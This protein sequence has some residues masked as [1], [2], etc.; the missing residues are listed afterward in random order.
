M[1]GKYKPGALTDVIVQHS[2]KNTDGGKKTKV[3]AKLASL[4]SP[5]NAAQNNQRTK[6]KATLENDSSDDVEG[7]QA[8]PGI[9]HETFQKKKKKTDKTKGKSVSKEETKIKEET[10]N[11]K[12]PRDTQRKNRKIR[13]RDETNDSKTVF[14]GN[15]PVSLQKKDL[16]KLFKTCGKIVSVRFR[17]PPTKDPRIPKKVISIKKDFHPERPTIVGFVCFEE[18]KSAQKALKLNGREVE[19]RHIRVDLAS[20]SKEHNHRCSVFVGNLDV[21]IDE[22]QIW[23][24]FSDCG[25]IVSVRII[26]DNKTGLGKGFCYIQFDSP[27]AVGLASHLNGSKLASREIRVMRSQENPG[28]PK[29]TGIDQKGKP[30]A[31]KN[32]KNKHGE[33]TV[34][35][36]KS[37]KKLKKD[38][39][40]KKMRSSDAKKVRKNKAIFSNSFKSSKESG[41]KMNKKMN[42]HQKPTGSKGK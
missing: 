20:K 31:K 21:R 23:S 19:G 9:V 7:Y 6:S 11:T 8:S 25:Q 15:W 38:K 36:G 37:A 17:C 13:I 39:K 32:F 18:E 35:K 14:V 28:L 10:E 22:E 26:R 3:K 1:D 16:M 29:K 24:H 40:L 42:T 2:Q 34:N 30:H 27:D 41:V 5:E 4:F 33:E 12:N